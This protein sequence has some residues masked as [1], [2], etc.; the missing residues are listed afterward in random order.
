MNR[1]LRRALARA[2]R[3][4]TDGRE[5]RVVRM[6]PDPVEYALSARRPIEDAQREHLQMQVHSAIFA[7]GHGSA[8]ETDVVHLR[9]AANIT[10]MLVEQTMGRDASGLSVLADATAAAQRAQEALLNIQERHKRVGRWGLDGQELRHL[11]AMA[12]LHDQFLEA[13]DQRTVAA[14]VAAAVE[15]IRL[16]HSATTVAQLRQAEQQAE[17]EGPQP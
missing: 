8:E 3:G 12:D 11:N 16:G 4:R 17:Q 13:A 1:H 5:P 14:A 9:S 10:L 6:S 2:E 7:L 15:R